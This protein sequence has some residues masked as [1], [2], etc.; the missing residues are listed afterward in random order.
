[1]K[2]YEFEFRCRRCGVVVRAP[3]DFDTRLE[4]GENLANYERGH[5][6]EVHDCGVEALGPGAG[7]AYLIGVRILED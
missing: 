4:I 1:M 3:A 7:I 5:I 6:F 2:R